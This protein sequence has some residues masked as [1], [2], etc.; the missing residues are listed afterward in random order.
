MQ[1]PIA[2]RLLSLICTAAQR[3]YHLFH[4]ENAAAAQLQNAANLYSKSAFI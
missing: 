1:V 3:A 2:L 4:N